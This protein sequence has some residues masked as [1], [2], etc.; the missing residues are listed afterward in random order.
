MLDY[1]YCQVNWFKLASLRTPDQNDHSTY[2]NSEL[3]VYELW[4]EPVIKGFLGILS[5]NDVVMPWLTQN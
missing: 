3:Q 1:D 2:H 5:A 4:L